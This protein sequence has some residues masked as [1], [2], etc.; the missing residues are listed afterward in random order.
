MN[1]AHAL[2]GTL[3]A[4][5]VTV[6][7]AN[8][9]TS[10]MHFVAGLDDA[11]DV[12]GVLCLFEGVATGAADG[13]ARVTGRPAATLLHLGPGLANGW[14][15]LHNARRARVPLVNIVGDHA[16]YHARY[17]APLQSDVAAVAGALDGWVRRAGHADTVARDA[18]D[19]VAAAYGPPGRVATLILPA[20]TS[21]GHLADAPATW[22]RAVRA[23]PR[24][25]DPAALTRTIERLR[26]GRAALFV[27]G[28]A[29]CAEGLALAQRV[30]AAS[31]ARVIMETFPALVD[32]GAGRFNPERLIYL[33][34]FAIG[35]LR[36]LDTLVLLGATAPVGFFAYPDVPSELVAEGCEVLNLAAP[37]VDAVGA[38]RALAEAL[39][40]PPVAAESGQPPAAPTGELTGPLFAAAVGATLP[41][42]VVVVDE[43]NTGGVHLFGAT[44]FSPPHRWLTLTGG[45][46]GFGLPVAVGAALGHGGRVLALE[47]DGSAMYTPQALWTMAREQLDVT[48]VVLANRSYAILHL[49]RQRVGAGAGAPS[50]RLLDLVD[51]DL[52]FV[53]L[54]AAMGVPAWRVHSGEDLTATLRRS[55]A[56][57]GPSLIEAVMPAGLT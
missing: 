56:T 30:A 37:G 35:Q 14:A 44:R 31:G 42:N 26:A 43:S 3:G 12:R 52:D 21:W 32:R 9:G 24:A 20:D 7:F 4:N 36:D 33:S 5:G 55:Y 41:E 16:T 23:S 18:A 50:Q 38:L 17:D 53:E 57:P 8:P 2:L 46:I 13:Y 47:A 28:D 1:G 39:G 51:P 27:G 19:A 48:V 25:A 40:A 22:P 54:A 15:N 45:A 29:A 10:E 34:E 6:C 11:P 49:E